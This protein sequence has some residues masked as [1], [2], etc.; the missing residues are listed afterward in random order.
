MKLNII[1]PDSLNEITLEQYQK[2]TKLNTKEN[3]GSAF[4]LHKMIE[5]FCNVNLKDIATIKYNDV[6]KLAEHLNKIFDV[7]SELINTFNLD[8]IEY[9]FIPKL[10]DMTLGEYIDLDTYLGDW[11]N[12]HKAMAVLYRPIKHKKQHRYQIQNYKGTNDKLLKMPLDIVMGSMVFFYNLNNELLK[13]TL[14]F[15]DNEI[16]NN[17]TSHQ[18]EALERSGVSTNQFGVLLKGMLPSLVQ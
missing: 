9:G 3:E 17:L 11:N 1:V 14:N 12:I 15:L 10:D 7:K 13:I 5:I 16:P 2:F 4:L 8:N 6:Q 18:L